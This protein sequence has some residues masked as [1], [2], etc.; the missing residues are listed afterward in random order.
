MDPRD[1]VQF[2]VKPL[3]TPYRRIESVGVM[4]LIGAVQP[5]VDTGDTDTQMLGL[6]KRMA[7][8]MPPVTCP[9]FYPKLA[10]FV[11]RWLRERNIQPLSVELDLGFK[12]WLEKTNYPEWRKVE[13]RETHEK[14]IKLN[15]KERGKYV[16]FGVDVFTKDETY[17]DYKMARLIFARSDAAKCYF[18]PYFKA[19]EE[20]IFDVETNPEFIKHV[21]VCERGRYIEQRL[22]IHGATYIAT[23]YSSFE[24]HFSKEL[25][26]ACEFI[27]YEH[28]LSE[29][30]EGPE[31]M[32]T[33]RE[34]LG[35]VN[36]IKNRNFKGLVTACRM[37]GEMN[38]SLGNGFANLMLM[39]FACDQIG[40]KLVGVVEG[41]DGLFAFP[42]GPRPTT[43][44]LSSYGCNIKLVEHDEL[45]TAS[46]CGLIYDKE[47]KEV[48][49]DPLDVISTIGWLRRPYLHAHRKKQ[50]AVLR[51]KGLS[52]LCS[53]PA[54]PIVSTL[55][56]KIC[57]LTRG[58]DVR[59]IIDSRHTTWWER[60]RY[61]EMLAAP[62]FY[63]VKKE[64]GLGTRLL[65]EQMYGINVDMQRLV[66]EE[67]ESW[68]ELGPMHLY[69]LVR[70]C[71]PSWTSYYDTY[72]FERDNDQKS[73]K[74]FVQP[75][76]N[77]H[78]SVDYKNFKGYIQELRDA[79]DLESLPHRSQK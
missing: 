79:D 60:E 25:M 52:I 12:T 40:Q 21:P 10:R 51:A 45:S 44:Q 4:P 30:P 75:A 2:V 5:H 36:R 71:P 26:E 9:D 39:S 35:G 47:D 46:F 63:N 16:N 33:I 15:H 78:S 54:C 68:T 41:D 49:T 53:Y 69:S 11:K 37:S 14:F 27:M 28:M 6:L 48:I 23:D 20:R 55:A 22:R 32:K 76:V 64:I 8:K 17:T 72:V 66:E 58:M 61:A 42:P 18:G 3:T 56:R 70:L 7:A 65:V 77:T 74:L 67:I 34:Q 62:K 38:T 24:A 31:V 59:H 19:I 13:L 43:E 57:D 1:D 29:L 50:L 73:I